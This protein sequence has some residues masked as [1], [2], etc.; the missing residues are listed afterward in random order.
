MTKEEKL[1]ALEEWL[2]KNRIWFNEQAEIING[3]NVPVILP[4]FHIAVLICDEKDENEYYRC[5]NGLY[6][7]LFI[8]DSESV[9][10]IE[11]K[12]KNLTVDLTCVHECR[13]IW[14]DLTMDDRRLFHTHGKKS[15]W[16]NFFKTVT[17]A[18]KVSGCDFRGV[19][20]IAEGVVIGAK[21]KAEAERKAE[22][23]RKKLAQ[24]KP[25]RKRI[26]VARVKYEKVN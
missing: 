2:V 20:Y 4:K 9:E 1:Q 7:L 12:M 24:A 11:E 5:L 19:R 6:R 26:H 15:S 23:E 18:V 17:E 3:C 16:K 10:F 8:R 13:K 21:I 22:E 25:K 14:A